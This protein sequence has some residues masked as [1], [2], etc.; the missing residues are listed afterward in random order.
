[1]KKIVKILSVIF[2]GLTLF[3]IFMIF[4]V[5]MNY[6][7][8]EIVLPDIKTHQ[9]SLP[10][11]SFT[12]PEEAYHFVGEYPPFNIPFTAPI[13]QLPNLQPILSYYG[14]NGRPDMGKDNPPLHFVLNENKSQAS[15]LSG[16]KIYL[17]YDRNLSTPQYVFSPN[18]SETPL[19][20]IAQAMDNEAKIRLYMK[21]SM[22]NQSNAVLS[23]DETFTEFI[24]PQKE[25]IQHYQPAKAWSIGRWNVDPTLLS[26]QHAKWYGEDK[27][28]ELHGGEEYQDLIQKHRI[29]FGEGNEIYSIYISQGDIA[30]WKD[31]AWKAVSSKDETVGYPLL[32]IKKVDERLI[33]MIL[34]DIDGKNRMN[35]NL[36]KTNEPC[37][38]Q[39]FQQQFKFVAARTRTQYIFEVN[40]KRLLLQPRDWLVFHENEWKKLTT[41]EEIDDYLYRKI[42]GPLFVF[43]DI[44]KKEDGHYFVGTFFNSSRSNSQAVEFMLFQPQHTAVH[45]PDQDEKNISFNREQS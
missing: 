6:E 37:L 29:D 42:I 36:I 15:A 30:I 24:L 26:R 32:Q 28:I 39:G 5:K 12:F 3:F 7:R 22:I 2:S 31:D 8:K 40:K 38:A 45:S 17:L 33:S 35:M 34:W 25:L 27:F 10:K 43:H 44:Q 23:D 41:E 16:E 11:G 13:M 18:N 1:M 21:T 19:W 20:I 9:R 14:P 4:I